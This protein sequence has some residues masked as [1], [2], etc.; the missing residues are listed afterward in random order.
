[1]KI[2]LMTK[3]DE[4]KGT[5]YTRHKNK[6]EYK[7]RCNSV[8]QVVDVS[9]KGYK[10][11]LIYNNFEEIVFH[12]EAFN[13]DTKQYYEFQACLWCP[14]SNRFTLK[15]LLD[16][17]IYTFTYFYDDEHDDY[18]YKKVFKYNIIE[19]FSKPMRFPSNL[20]MYESKYLEKYKKEFI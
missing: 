19:K 3:I 18:K 6:Y 2:K 14:R 17:A 13:Y 9:F 1:M 20:F 12:I 5:I 4:N 7:Q 8:I 15:E 11:N 16:L 10:P